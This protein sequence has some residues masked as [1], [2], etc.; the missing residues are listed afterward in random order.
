VAPHDALLQQTPSTQLPVAHSPGVR[1]AW[2]S[3]FLQVP[4]GAQVK[5]T[6]QPAVRQ[7]TPSAQL[8]LAQVLPAT[9]AVPGGDLH[10][11]APSHWPLAGQ[12][13]TL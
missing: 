4:D 5:F 6:L 1:H 13:L 10:A 8:P 3:T 2:P 7:Q 11:P 12:A 9:H